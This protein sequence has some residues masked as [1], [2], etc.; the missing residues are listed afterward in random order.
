M[1]L[2]RFHH[3]LPVVGKLHEFHKLQGVVPSINLLLQEAGPHS[4]IPP[5]IPWRFI[6]AREKY[7]REYFAELLDNTGFWR[8][9]SP[10][11]HQGST[12]EC[13]RAKAQVSN[14]AL[15]E[16]SKV[17]VYIEQK[18]QPRLMKS[19]LKSRR[20]VTFVTNFPRTRDLE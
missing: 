11:L 12:T 4:Y 2:G 5:P 13:C 9:C 18:P 17:L 16:C 1:R 14:Q 20:G 10:W 3:L 15:R 8:V 7:C 6:F 19:V